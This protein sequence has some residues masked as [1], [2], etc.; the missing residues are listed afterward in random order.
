[1]KSTGLLNGSCLARHVSTVGIRV[2]IIMMATAI[3]FL[4]ESESMYV[5]CINHEVNIFS[6]HTLCLFSV[7][8]Q[9]G[10]KFFSYEQHYQKCIG[11]DNGGNCA[12]WSPELHT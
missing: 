4:I 5:M 2:A 12:G 9:F 1:M 11:I 3:L 7:T 10:F 6:S 8:L